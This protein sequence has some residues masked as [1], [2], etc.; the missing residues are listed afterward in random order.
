MRLPRTIRGVVFDLGGV[1]TTNMR[2]ETLNEVYGTFWFSERPRAVWGPLYIK[3][4][5]GQL[6]P[7]FTDPRSS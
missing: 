5:L 1:I 4:T 6:D 3:A 7:D 2:V